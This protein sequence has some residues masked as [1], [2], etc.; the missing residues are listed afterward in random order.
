[1][2]PAKDKRG[3]R[4]RFAENNIFIREEWPFPGQRNFDQPSCVYLYIAQHNHESFS[5]QVEF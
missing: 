5:M 4:E 1:M 3:V 2:G